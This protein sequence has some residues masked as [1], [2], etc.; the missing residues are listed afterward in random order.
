M[1]T[2]CLVDEHEDLAALAQRMVEA[3]KDDQ[4]DEAESI[5]RRLCEEVPGFDEILTFPVLFAIQR[6]NVVAALQ[7]ING[8]PEDRCPELKALCLYLIQDPTWHAIAHAHEDDQDPHVRQ[9]MR[10]LL[11][12]EAEPC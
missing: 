5:H 1:Q 9:A 2:T 11:G 3:L 6:G 4:L 8:L 7:F 10:D 12:R